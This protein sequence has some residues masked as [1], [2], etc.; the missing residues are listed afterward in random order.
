MQLQHWYQTLNKALKVIVL[1]KISLLNNWTNVI[2][3]F[4]RYHLHQKIYSLNLL[5]LQTFAPYHLDFSLFKTMLYVL[6]ANLWP[7]SGLIWHFEIKRS[8]RGATS[9]KYGEMF[10]SWRVCFAQN[11]MNCTIILVKDPGFFMINVSCK[12]W[13]M[14][15]T[16]V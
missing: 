15:D 16:F 13:R 14:T 9:A 7:P 6:F 3:L 12:I 5:S 4:T 8:N 11:E 2:K 10:S 1:H